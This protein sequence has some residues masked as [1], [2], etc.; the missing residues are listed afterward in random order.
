MMANPHT[1]GGRQAG[2]LRVLA[3]HLERW[4]LCPVRSLHEIVGVQEFRPASEEI[5][6]FV[7]WARSLG[8]EALRVMA[9]TDEDWSA[10]YATGVIAGYAVQVWGSVTHL[11]PM[12]SITV[13]ELAHFAEHATLPEGGDPR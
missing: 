8:A 5:A 2:F 13:T 4:E 6:D 3:D 7:A 9:I 1:P 11:S 12:A 10:V